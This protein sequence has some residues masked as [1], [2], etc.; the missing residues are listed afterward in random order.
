MVTV[1]NDSSHEHAQTEPAAVD[2]NPG[3]REKW[4]AINRLT[5][6]VRVHIGLLAVSAV[7]TGLI[8]A[9]F[10]VSVARIGLAV[11]ENQNE[12]TLTRGVSL[13]LTQA[14]IAAAILLGL[15]LLVSLAGVRVQMGLTY[16]VSTSL[17]RRLAQA[18]LRASWGV[19]QAQPSG[20]LQ[21]LVVTFPNHAS[22]LMATLSHAAGSALTLL[23][24]VGVALL[25]DAPATLIVVVVL[26]L[27]SLLLRPLRNVVGRRSQASI[28]HQMAFANGVAQVGALGVEI[29]AFGVRPQAEKHLDD[30]IGNDAAAQR[31]VGLIANAVSPIYVT[32]AYAAVLGA[33]VAVAAIGTGQLQS[34]GAVMLVMM[35]SLGYAQQMQS[36]AVALAQI[37]PFL[38]AIDE[39]VDEYESQ[40][41]S[42]GST[43]VV[44]IGPVEFSGVSF[45]YEPGTPVLEDVSFRIEPGEVIGIIGPSG[46]GKSTLVQLLL[47]LREPD[48]GQAKVGDVDLREVDREQWTSKVAFVPQDPLL[49]T[50]TVA[51]NIRMWRDQ[52]TDEQ[53]VAAARAAHVL[54]EIEALPDGFDADLGERGQKLSGGQ[55]QRISIARALAG[56]PE[57]VIMDEPTSA[58]D[59][60]AEAAIR[61]TITSLAGKVTVVVIAH[62]ISTLE[63]CDRLMVIQGGRISAFTTPAE[64]QRDSSFYRETLELAGFR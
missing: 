30:L 23:A 3:F 40:P 12:V 59:M 45:S 4:L 24:L 44:T 36:G 54:A 7:L 63:A 26:G 41:A 13:A 17:R 20:T 57:L 28:E 55:R 22:N 52:I 62:R 9:A 21:Q 58:L 43:P 6:Q 37:L 2:A 18:F 53:V 15:R 19:Q 16:R 8:E 38:R 29:Q 35:R 50:G 61:E 39:T 11:A 33:L 5:G 48:Q 31:R 49:I 10:L 27:L 46:G 25:V 42:S 14:I 51:E 47:G 60:K 1:P 34:V 56:G 64:L 32:F